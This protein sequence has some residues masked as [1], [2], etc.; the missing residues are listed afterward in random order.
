MEKTQSRRSQSIFKKYEF[1]I[2]PTIDGYIDTFFQDTNNVVN[3]GWTDIW[4][5]LQYPSGTPIKDNLTAVRL[6][7]MLAHSQKHVSF[8]NYV[9][10]YVH[11]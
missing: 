6:L 9:Y 8:A 11:V 5:E 3:A 10:T 2:L 7:K 1:G 4:T